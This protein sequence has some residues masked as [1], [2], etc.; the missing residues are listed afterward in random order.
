MKKKDMV[1]I[2][3]LTLVFVFLYSGYRVYLWVKSDKE[4]KRLETELFKK[5]IT[6]RET[7]AEAKIIVD[8]EELEKINSDIIAWI[9]VEGTYINYPILQGETDEYYMK[10]DI[11]RKYSSAGSIFIDSNAKIDFSDDN[12]VIYGHNMRNQRMFADLNKIY[13]GEIGTDVFVE[14]F[15]KIKNY[16]YKVFSVYVAEPTKEMIRREFLENQKDEYIENAVQKSNVKFETDID[17]SKTIITLI[18]CD[19]TGKNRIVVNA[20]S[21]N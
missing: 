21:C 1:N 5:V 16:K 9:R 15:T 2:L 4:T 19:S 7:E 17:S 8:F 3:L 20:V 18:T 14:L 6:E 10:K 13:N 12:T 11:Y